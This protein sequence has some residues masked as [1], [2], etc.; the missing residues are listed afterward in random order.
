MSKDSSAKYYQNNKE[1]LQK[2]VCERYPSFSK[3]E[4]KKATIR[5]WRIQNLTEE[6]KQRLVEHRKQHYK[7]RNIILVSNKFSF[8]KQDYIYFIGYK[9]DKKVRPICIFFQKW[10]HIEQTLMNLNVSGAHLGF[11]EGRG[12]NFRKRENQ[13][14]TEKNISVITFW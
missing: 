7:M 11:S 12:P 3:E 5:S 9:D 6:E 4:K 10:M 13:Y 1:R 14:K 8:G 2:K